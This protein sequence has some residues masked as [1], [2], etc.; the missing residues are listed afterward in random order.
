[1]VILIMIT[2]RIIYIMIAVMV[3]I[4]RN[5]K[6]ITLSCVSSSCIRCE[7]PRNDM[8]DDRRLMMIVVSCSCFSLVFKH[9]SITL[10]NYVFDSNN[11][12]KFSFEDNGSAFLFSEEHRFQ[13]LCASILINSYQD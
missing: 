12:F 6:M 7:S 3:T 10:Y 8:V 9:I 2:L 13:D 4:G 11:M 1:M 5:L